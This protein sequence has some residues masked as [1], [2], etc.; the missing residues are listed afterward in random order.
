MKDL[1]ILQLFFFPH[2]LQRSF[3][4]QRRQQV[5]PRHCRHEQVAFWKQQ[6]NSPICPV[7]LS[8]EKNL[9]N[10]SFTHKWRKRNVHHQKTGAQLQPIHLSGACHERQ[11]SQHQSSI[12]SRH[13]QSCCR[14]LLSWSHFAKGIC[15]LFC[16]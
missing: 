4:S 5:L 12:K 1:K 3:R 14:R 6:S 13:S 8:E 15:F 10:A 11:C 16:F 9:T 7:S 2:L